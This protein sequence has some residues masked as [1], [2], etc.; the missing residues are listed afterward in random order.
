[1]TKE[2]NCYVLMCPILFGNNDNHHNNGCVIEFNIANKT[3]IRGEAV[4][5]LTE[6]SFFLGKFNITGKLV[7]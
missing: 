3:M 7:M 1:M 2:S 5:Q 6:V 4:N